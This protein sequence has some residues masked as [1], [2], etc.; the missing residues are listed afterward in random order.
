MTLNQNSYDE[1]Q[2][3]VL[4]GL[5]AVRKRPGMYIGSTS[6]RGLHHLVWEVVDNSIDEAL[7]GY[8]TRIDVIVHKDNRITVIDNGRGIPVGEHA[9]MKRPALEVVLTVLHAGGKFGGDDSGYKVSGGLHGVGI[10]VVN[11]LSSHLLVRVKLHGK[12]HEQEYRQGKPQYDLRI[13]GETEE[14]GTTVTFTPD[15]EIFTETTEYDYEILQSRLRELAFLNKGIEINLTDERTDTSD[16]FMYEGGIKSFVEHLNRNKEALHQPPIYVEGSKENIQVE[17]AIQYNDSYTENIYSF[18]N[19]INTHEGGTHESGFKSALTRILNDYARKTNAIKES[20]SN[21]SGDDVREGLAAIIS[22]KIPEP[23]FEGQTKT[24]LG[25]SEV[26]GIVDSLFAEKLLEFLD[27]NPAIAKKI[28]EKGLQASRAREAARKARELT[29]RKSVL[30]VSSLPGKLADCSSKD[31]SISELYIVEGDSA[32]GSAKQGR[33]RHFQA[34]L[35]IRGKI[36]NVEKARLD[37]ILSNLEIRAIITAMGTGISDD[38]DI[39][40]ARYHKLI[41]MTDADVDGA[42]IRTLLL[43]YFYRYMRKLIEVGYVYI[44]QPPLYK[45]ER[46]KVARYAYSDKQR[47]EIMKEFGDGA[48]VNVQRYK[49]LGEM[50]AEQLW[51]TTMDPETRTLLQVTIQD[52]MDAD[53]VFDTLMGDNVEPRRNFIHQHAKYVKNLDI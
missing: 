36:L 10:S 40:K 38:F 45:L 41:I 24:K 5:E 20:G 44:A 42:H 7:A 21:L 33:D 30:E 1:N 16:S 31:A 39:A 43:T 6:S 26:R 27:E 14:T 46:G 32:G 52:A 3:Q 8:C 23:Q 22:V 2:I 12:I 28:V 9:K 49:G 4:E 51:D 50:D 35:P 15:P 34:I 25:N 48:K 53:S 47:D 17:V 29:R 19:N 18:A 13:I 11:A 37:K